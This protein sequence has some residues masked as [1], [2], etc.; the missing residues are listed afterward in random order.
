[1]N[2]FRNSIYVKINEFHIYGSSRLG[3]YESNE[4]I[5]W[6]SAF[7]A[8]NDNQLS[9]TEYSSYSANNSGF[10]FANLSGYRGK[11]RYELITLAH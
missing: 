7:D 8:N 11:I 4:V 5:A 3:V 2:T 10:M 9:E 6:R 1:M